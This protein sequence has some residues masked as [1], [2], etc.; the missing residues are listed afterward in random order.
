MHK[1]NYKCLHVGIEGLG[2]QKV[3]LYSLTAYILLKREFR[4]QEGNSVPFP[5][6]EHDFPGDGGQKGR[7]AWALRQDLVEG[8]VVDPSPEL[9]CKQF[10]IYNLVISVVLLLSN[11]KQIY[12]L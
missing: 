11:G 12:C 5:Y 10:L 3:M 1:C 8:G 7:K 9:T 2:K 4:Q 6:R